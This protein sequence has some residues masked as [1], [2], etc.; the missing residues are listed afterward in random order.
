MLFFIWFLDVSIFEAIEDG[1]IAYELVR[2]MD[3]YGR[4]F[5]INVTNRIARVITLCTHYRSGIHFA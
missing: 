2:P 3:L 4:W 5:T 1:H